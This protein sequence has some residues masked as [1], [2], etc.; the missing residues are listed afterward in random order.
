[1]ILIL[2]IQKGVKI[3]VIV[4]LENIKVGKAPLEVVVG[5]EIMKEAEDDIEGKVDPVR[6]V[7]V[8]KELEVQG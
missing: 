2:I 3:K 4:I 5:V 6:L 1:M 8:Q 7:R